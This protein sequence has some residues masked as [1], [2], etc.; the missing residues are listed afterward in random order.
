MQAMVATVLVDT[1]AD[2]DLQWPTVT[3]A[4]RLANAEARAKLEA[5]PE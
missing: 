5:E 4:D 2:L 3:E 1:I